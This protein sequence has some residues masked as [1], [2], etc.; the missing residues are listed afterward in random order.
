M[1]VLREQR[2]YAVVEAAQ[3]EHAAWSDLERAIRPD[4]ED[5]AAVRAYKQ[6]WRV[7]SRRLIEALEAL[8]TARR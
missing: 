2:E 5:E 7:A 6:R 8:K 3:E 4:V 1:H